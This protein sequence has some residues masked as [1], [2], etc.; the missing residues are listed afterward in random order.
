MFLMEDHGVCVLLD[1]VSWHLWNPSCFAWGDMQTRSAPRPRWPTPL[2]SFSCLVIHPIRRFYPLQHGA[3]VNQWDPRWDSQF[4]WVDNPPSDGLVHFGKP[5]S[6]WLVWFDNLPSVGLVQFD[7][8]LS[9]IVVF[10]DNLPPD[11]GSFGNLLSITVV[12]FDNLLPLSRS[13]EVTDGATVEFLTSALGYGIVL[14]GNGHQLVQNNLSILMQNNVTINV[15]INV[16]IL[17]TSLTVC[18]IAILV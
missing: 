8:L 17:G 10:F 7:N 5:L 2:G 12:R 6:G 4:T 16:S 11:S 18:H 3:K 9:V 14:K 13:L 15:Q 1:V